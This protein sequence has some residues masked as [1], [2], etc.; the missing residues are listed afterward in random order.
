MMST[1]TSNKA[2][3]LSVA[4]YAADLAG[5]GV[6]ILPGGPG[7]FWAGFASGTMMRRPAFHLAPPTSHE[8]RQVLWRGR[9]AI[10]SYLLEP[11]ERHPPNAWLYIC[12]DQA[13]AL[14]KLA[15]TMRRNVHRGLKE[16]AITLLTAEQVLAHGCQAYCDTQHRIGL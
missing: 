7:T 9:A 15:P 5:S 12:T 8:V 6:R 1:Q 14:E 2:R 16:L 11:D 10:A 13:Y 4:D 3:P